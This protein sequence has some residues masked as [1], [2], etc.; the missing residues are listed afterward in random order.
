MDI[1]I[2]D[3]VSAPDVVD[4]WFDPICP[5]AWL[6]SRWIADVAPRRHLEVRWHV[7]SLSVLNA[8]RDVTAEYA[9]LMARAW[10]PVRILIAAS[11]S[12]GEDLLE[13]LYR[14]HGTLIHEQQRPVSRDLSVEA[15]A[16]CGLPA[17]LVQ[18]GDG[19][20]HDEAL[21]ASHR[22]G[23]DPVGYD[24]GTPV[25][26]VA[27]TAFFG[28]VLS[29]VPTGEAADRLWDGVRSAAAYPYFYE[30]KRSRTEA[31]Q[32]AVDPSGA[33]AP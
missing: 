19:P 15:L 7:M 16:T 26:H 18:A 23:M 10:G 29:R 21:R 32:V 24:V 4:F 30:L 25:I 27:G 20:E 13:P 22:A 1:D 2:A 11:E 28:P 31:P 8:D 33:E 14:A 12:L 5:F 17:E 6:A 3:P 9:D